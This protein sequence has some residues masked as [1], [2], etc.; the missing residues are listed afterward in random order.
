MQMCEEYN[1]YMTDD[2]MSSIHNYF[3]KIVENKDSNFGNARE[4]RKM[5]EKVTLNQSMR[6]AELPPEKKTTYS[7]LVT[8]TKGDIIFA[9]E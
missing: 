8:I 9:G 5:F 1:L 6:I 2:A 3:H 4:V 7:D